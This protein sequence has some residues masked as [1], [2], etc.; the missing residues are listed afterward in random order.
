MQMEEVATLNACQYRS[1]TGQLADTPTR[2]T[3]RDW[4]TGGLADAAFERKLSTQSRRWHPRLVQYA[5]C[6]VRELS[7]ITDR[8]SWSV[9]T[10]LHYA[11]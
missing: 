10:K 5:S 4:T 11:S 7:S 9:K 3:S 1:L 6:L 8:S 2:W